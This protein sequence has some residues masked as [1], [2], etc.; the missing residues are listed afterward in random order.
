MTTV[1]LHGGLLATLNSA[2]PEALNALHK[3]DISLSDCPRGGGSAGLT[4][5]L[6]LSCR[7]LDSNPA[8]FHTVVELSL[9]RGLFVS[10]AVN[11]MLTGVNN[12]PVF[13][14]VACYSSSVPNVVAN[15]NSGPA[16]ALPL[17]P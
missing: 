3:G 4:G 15:C 10:L 7:H 2:A 11:N 16:W 14:I 8:R 5:L 6:R 1:T 12:H 9:R 17:F 13:N